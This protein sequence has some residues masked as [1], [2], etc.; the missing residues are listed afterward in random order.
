MKLSLVVIEDGSILEDEHGSRPEV[1]D[2]S[3][4][5]DDVGLQRCGYHRSC[6]K[7]QRLG[8]HR[9]WIEDESA[10]ELAKDCATQVDRQSLGAHR[11]DASSSKAERFAVVHC[12]D[13]F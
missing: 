6:N 1:A 4:P 8:Y 11:R 9:R 7:L 13:V 2:G 5:E 10:E 3:I 12:L